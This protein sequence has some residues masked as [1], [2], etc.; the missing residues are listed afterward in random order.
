MTRR[1]VML[2]L[3]AL[4]AAVFFYLSRFWYLSLWPRPG[5]FG[6]SELRPQGGL[7]AQ[8]LRGTDAAPFELLIWA[9]GCF[10]LLTLA[11]KLYDYATTPK[12]AGEPH[13]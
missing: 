12:D 3:V 10:V 1:I 4:I 11:Q 9:L 13:E 2:T 7:V 5:L 8:W 6:L